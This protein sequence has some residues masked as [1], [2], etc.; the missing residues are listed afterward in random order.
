MGDR[1]KG[2]LKIHV[3]NI[4]RITL[5][6]GSGW[7]LIRK[8]KFETKKFFESVNIWPFWVH[9]SDFSPCRVRSMPGGK[10]LTL[11]K[12]RLIFLRIWRRFRSCVFLNFSSTPSINDFTGVGMFY[13]L[14]ILYTMLPQSIF[15]LLQTRVSQSFLAGFRRKKN[16]QNR[17][18][19]F[20][21]MT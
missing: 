12:M 19:I 9:F 16:R 13:W 8:P 17:H 6:P 20:Y 1:I 5:V 10:N 3:N 11:D 7:I 15:W 14:D 2:L 18:K 21:L 4:N